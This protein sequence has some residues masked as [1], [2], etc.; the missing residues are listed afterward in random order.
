[1]SSPQT[2]PESQ[3]KAEG[4]MPEQT[5][6]PEQQK[7]WAMAPAQPTGA[8]SGWLAFAGSLIAMIGIFN[9]IG[10][11]TALFRPTYYLVGTAQ[12]LVFDFAAWGWFWL[13]LGVVQVVAGVGC[14]YGQMWARMTGIG[15]AALSAIAHLAFFAAFP[16]WSLVVIAMS[17]LVI[18]GLMVPPR[19]AVA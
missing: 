1:M 9:I 8:M 6:A 16:L 10:G 11:I 14:M 12:L 3:A 15:L 2:G 19:G 13:A 17:V 4:T 18:Y 7:Q 5:A